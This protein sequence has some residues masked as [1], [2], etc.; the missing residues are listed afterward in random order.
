MLH[1]EREL[2]DMKVT[3]TEQRARLRAEVQAVSTKVEAVAEM[4]ADTKA[5]TSEIVALLK[6]MRL[7]GALTKWVGLPGGIGSVIYVIGDIKKW[8]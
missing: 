4:A 2:A 8:W 7:L 5:D 1:V 6:G 3:S